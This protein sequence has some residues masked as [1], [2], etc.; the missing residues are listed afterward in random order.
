MVL[1]ASSSSSSSSSIGGGGAVV[2][3]GAGVLGALVCGAQAGA[4]AE[5]HDGL[6]GGVVVERVQQDLQV[7]A[8]VGLPLAD[9]VEELGDARVG[10]A[11]CC[12]RSGC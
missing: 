8:E 7:P 3:A 11:F 5:Q 4:Q 1:S 9:H 12:C 6:G 10:G 2:A